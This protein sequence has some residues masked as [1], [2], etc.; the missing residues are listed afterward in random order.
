MYKLLFKSVVYYFYNLIQ[1]KLYIE[2]L[3]KIISDKEI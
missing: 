1:T 3:L 2:V